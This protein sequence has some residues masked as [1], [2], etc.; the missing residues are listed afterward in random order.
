MG[1]ARPDA[2]NT[3]NGNMPVNVTVDDIGSDS[4]VQFRQR[5][6]GELRQFKHCQSSL[7]LGV[8]QTCRSLADNVFFEVGTLTSNGFKLRYKVSL[9]RILKHRL[10]NLCGIHL[11]LFQ[12]VSRR[13]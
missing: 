12:F 8:R 11:H 10:Q 2:T 5:Q 6:A 3:I 4:K 9:G 7:L 1:N 13:I